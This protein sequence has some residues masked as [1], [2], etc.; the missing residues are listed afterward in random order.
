MNKYELTIVLPEKTTIAKKK[1]VLEAIEKI[2]KMGK[3][4]VGEVNDWGEKDLAYPIEKQERGLFIHLPLELEP[5]FV[6]QLDT[7]LKMDE[8]IIRHLIVR[9]EK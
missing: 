7:K 6:S 1:S 9:K 4:V 5:A 3:G 8:N 2:V